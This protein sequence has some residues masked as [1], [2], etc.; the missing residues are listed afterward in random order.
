MKIIYLLSIACGMATVLTGCSQ[1]TPAPV[2]PAP[3]STA[4]QTT[5][6]SEAQKPKKNPNSPVYTDKDGHKWLGKVPFDVYDVF[7]DDPVLIASNQTPIP[8]R[9]IAS[10]SNTD[11][12]TNTMASKVESKPEPKPTENKPADSKT[13]WA[14][15][16]P[17]NIL[18]DES[19]EL[20][21]QL[22]ASLRSV[23]TYNKSFAQIQML[24]ATMASTA[25]IASEHPEEIR[26]KNNAIALR[27]LAGIMVVNATERGRPNFEKTQIPFEKIL[28]ILNGDTPSDLPA[29]PEESDMSS[30]VD[31][32]L[33]M[34][35]MQLALNKIRSNVQKKSDLKSQGSDIVHEASLLA[36]WV[37]LTSHLD[38]A[39][40][41]EAA[42][43]TFA[44]EM[45]KASQD[46]IDAA[47]KEKFDEY[48]T[49]ISTIQQKCDG[50]H[51]S[52]R[53]E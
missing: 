33:L 18:A 52:Y 20:R 28:S 46:A 14:D 13:S 37:K 23:G 5:S 30:S 47:Q 22:S 9:A 49:A 31:R 51:R 11:N 1:N 41:D 38:Y 35:R 26:W 36:A 17:I 40:T 44:K 27:D 39:F 6:N 7:F 2:S 25:Q 45:I 19:K 8:G 50:C 15:L 43:Q 42:Y 53:F 24:A 32:G 12:D 29:P 34:T 16:V 10:N 3:N 21:N 4:T 48:K